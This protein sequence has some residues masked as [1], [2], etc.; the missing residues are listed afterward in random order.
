MRR[1]LPVC[2]LI[3]AIVCAVWCCDAAAKS[4]Y[5]VR[6]TSSIATAGVETSLH[7][8]APPSLQKQT[9]L[10]IGL[11]DS[12]RPIGSVYAIPA[13]SRAPYGIS[14]FRE[15]ARVVMR[16]APKASSEQ[17][18][19]LRVKLYLA[20]LQQFSWAFVAVDVSAS[21]ATRV[22]LLAEG[23]LPINVEYG[24][25]NFDADQ[26]HPTGAVKAIYADVNG[27]YALREYA[28]YYQVFDSQTGALLA[29]RVGKSPAFSPS[30]RFVLAWNGVST[31]ELFDIPAGVAMQIADETQWPTYGLVQHAVWVNGDAVLILD[32]GRK[33]G[34][35]IAITMSDWRNRPGEYLGCNGCAAYGNVPMD[36]DLDNLVVTLRDTMAMGDETSADQVMTLSET[37]EPDSASPPVFKDRI[38]NKRN[39]STFAWRSTDRFVFAEV[40]ALTG[41]KDRTRNSAANR[42][43]ASW[44]LEQQARARTLQ[45]VAS[46]TILSPRRSPELAALT[47]R[48]MEVG[49]QKYS[50]GAKPMRLSATLEAHGVRLRP[51]LQGRII[52]LPYKSDS[53][54][55]NLSRRVT[56]EVL[57]LMP[58]GQPESLYL[59]QLPKPMRSR[60]FVSR[61]AATS[62]ILGEEDMSEQTPVTTK[63]LRPLLSAWGLVGVTHFDLP[64][65]RLVVAQHLDSYG[66]SNEAYGDLV[67]VWI[68]K[69]GSPH[70]IERLAAHHTDEDEGSS[71][72][73]RSPLHADGQ[74][75]NLAYR[76]ELVIQVS[77][78]DVLLITS[79]ST[80]TTTSYKLPT[81]TR[82]SHFS[83]KESQAQLREVSLTQ[84]G[85]ALFRITSVGA[86]SLQGISDNAPSIRGRYANGELLMYDNYG[87]FELTAE[88]GEL[89][90]IRLQGSPALI[91]AE[92]FGSIALQPGTLIRSLG[93]LSPP[94]PM[95]WRPPIVEARSEGEAAVDVALRSTV[96]LRALEVFVDGVEVARLPVT[97]GFATIR[98]QRAQYPLG[99]WTTFVAEDLRGGR[100]IPVA[101]THERTSRRGR[102]GIL[103][104]GIDR[105]QS[106]AISDLAYAGSDA[107]RTAAAF[108]RSLRKSYATVVKTVVTDDSPL[109]KSDGKLAERIQTFAEAIGPTD[110]LVLFISAHGLVGP[111]GLEIALP[112]TP[113]SSAPRLSFEAIATA[114]TKARGRL[115]VVL[116]T[117]HAGGATHDSAVTELLKRNPALAVVA[118]SKGDE[119][120]SEGPTWRGGVFSYALVR[121]LQTRHQSVRAGLD[122]DRVFAQVR[123]FVQTSTNGRQ[124]PM[125]RLNR[126]V[127]PFPL[128]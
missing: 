19:E 88:A 10:V 42:A 46:S 59:D 128:D 85:K 38:A 112:A 54:F 52:T 9:F 127:G 49:S 86:W 21:E 123:Q 113:E 70:R 34:T 95:L 37:A 12:A 82:L 6:A 115:F 61:E 69:D 80:G 43:S 118:A 71:P 26:Q 4:D 27:R 60:A 45:R 97:G 107:V 63:P 101:I 102:L 32:H 72:D 64:A 30:G 25:A 28:D 40:P 81:L 103:S 68:P 29:S 53:R 20:G 36:V 93:K 2:Y 106:D 41:D 119:R 33:G 126:S 65:A 22:K 91:P 114:L 51:N 18:S 67:A 3:F 100:S 62:L 124:L 44:D 1:E 15:N 57:A 7:W 116:D 11:P 92:Q 121:A 5:E 104:I 109:L 87:R 48:D 58:R 23:S 79:R 83:T 105:Y 78:P 17:Q 111:R 73:Q 56:K 31:A 94:A 75:L 77:Q 47:Y 74:L 50:E 122:V 120:S 98:Y 99:R 24:G 125:L 14:Q 66:T 39:A 96:G 84:D 117:C 8:R 90:F 16:L 55:E 35:T 76:P 13:G 110:T 89:S 108:E